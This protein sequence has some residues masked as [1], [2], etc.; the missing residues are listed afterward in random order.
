M[1]RGFLN[2]IGFTSQ[3]KLGAQRDLASI[4][5]LS[6]DLEVAIYGMMILLTNYSFR[7]QIQQCYS[8]VT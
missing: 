4:V 3:R 2:C 6:S 1:A 7:L 8:S 5:P